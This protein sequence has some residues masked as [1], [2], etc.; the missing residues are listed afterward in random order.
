MINF[1]V[2]GTSNIT[3]EFVSAALR[4]GR[5][6]LAAVYSRTIQ[7]GQEFAEKFGC[8]KVYTSLTDLA[9]D[10]T[11]TAVYV[12]SP[13]AL[14]YE[15]SKFLLE[16]G[17]NVISEKTI[18][19]NADE[20]LELK[21]VADKGNVIIMDA[22]M[23]RH[24]VNREKIIEGIKKIGNIN[25]ARIDF[26]KLSARYFTY[27]AGKDENIFNMKLGAGAL[28]DIG[29]YCVYAAVDLFGMPKNITA[30]TN[31]LRDGADGSGV[32]LF[33]YG[34]F[35]AVLTYGKVSQSGIGSEILGDNGTVVIGSISQFDDIKLIID[36]RTE[37]LCAPTDKVEIM[38]G[39]AIA[40]ANY[41]EN[42]ELFA[43]EYQDVTNLTHNV[44]ICLDVI[45]NKANIKYN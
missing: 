29:V 39:E 38:M 2:I 9:N 20:F 42:K 17:K 33:D 43:D 40:F 32:V 10:K 24:S 11:I 19:S 16:N 12:A 25:L 13:N 37:T 41:I 7:K 23:S 45:K 31:F 35:D 15:Q 36:G 28:T 44:L 22:I 5:F 8:D 14:H 4:T 1:A 3:F 6:N 30:K 18:T 21:K 27:I 34:N 26:S